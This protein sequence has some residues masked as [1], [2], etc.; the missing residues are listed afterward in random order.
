MAGA[1][2]GGG[3]ND[4]GPIFRRKCA[5]PVSERNRL[6]L[7]QL[8]ERDIDVADVEVDHWLAGLVRR[9]AR[10]IPGGFAVADGVEQVRPDLVWLHARKH[11]KE[12]TNCG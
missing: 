9:I 2:V 10:D 8:G 12:R 4:V 3:E 7:P 5:E 6:T 11:V 1:E